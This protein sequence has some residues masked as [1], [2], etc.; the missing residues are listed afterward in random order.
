MIYAAGMLIVLFCILL[1]IIM[2]LSIIAIVLFIRFDRKQK[3]HSVL[4][5]YPLLG[6]IRYFFEHIGPEL[7][8]Y[9]FDNDL[10]GRPFSREDYEQ[11]VRGAKYKR[12]VM[13]FGSK[14]DFNG[15]GYYIRND[16]FPTLSEE[17]QMDQNT[18]A[19]TKR[20][21]LLQDPL[22]A[23]R[24]EKLEDDH[25][26]AFLLK[27]EDAVVIGPQTKNPF[28]TKG[29]IGMSAMSYGSL[30]KNAITA[31]SKGLGIAQGSWMNTGEGGLSSY[32][33]EGNVDVIMQIGPALF[34]VR[35]ENGQFDYDELKRKSDIPQV[36]AFE[37][38]LAQGAKARGGHI[39]GMKVTPE[40]ADIRGVVPYESIDSP[41]RFQA[42]DDIPA[43]FTFMRKIRE[44]ANKPVGM[45]LVV[46]SIDSIVPL[47]KHMKETGE[48]PDFI[49][50]DGAEGGT[51]ASFQELIDSVGL[52]IRSGLPIVHETLK[53]YGVRDRVK[54]IAS[55][56]MFTPDRIAIALAMGAD[57]VNIARGFMISVGCIQTLK[58]HENVC[59]VGVATTDPE[60]EKALVIDEKKHRAA[61]YLISLRKGLYRVAA[62]AGL[63]SPV[64]FSEKNIMYK[65]DAGRILPLE[66]MLA[67][68]QNQIS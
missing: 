36:K 40:I 13:S 58:C 5:N 56:K 39:D 23:Q 42:F 46:G 14:Q 32:H 43:M 45:K 62:A 53:K 22:F 66:K 20:Y 49:T 52:P 17:L 67:D 24:K 18:I 37:I 7:R 60:L 6:R 65:D 29:L 26:L 38:K 10:E 55:A 59:P 34:G 3:G 16:M 28:V 35:D 15:D 51:G 63:N 64:Q 57:L 25:S 11:I 19:L 8:Q 31:L 12:D 1:T 54:I 2:I 41:N 30:G 33:L 27:E 48:G 44:T 9:W 61:N 47:A 4:R 50:V 68:I 21:L